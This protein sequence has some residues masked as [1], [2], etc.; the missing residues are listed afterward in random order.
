MDVLTGLL[1]GPRA[2]SAFLLKSMLDPPWSLRIQDEAPLTVVTVLTG[3]AWLVLDGHEP[4]QLQPGGVAIVRGPGHYTLADDPKRTPTVIVHPGQLTTDIEGEELCEAMDLGLRTWGTSA[5][6][7]VTMVT[8]TYQTPTEISRL[9]LETLPPMIVI[10][11][12]D[13]DSPFLQLLANEMAK[14]HVGQEVVLD[15]LLDLVVVAALRNWIGQEGSESPGKLG[16]RHDP[17]VQ[18]ALELVQRDPAHA[19]TVATLAAETGVS[20]AAFARRFSNVMGMPPMAYLT[21]WRLALAA[22]SLRDPRKTIG[23]VAREVGYGSAFALSTAFK[24]IRGVSPH[25]YRMADRA[26]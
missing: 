21:Q 4:A 26:S 12:A 8:G 20:R 23:A 18:T 17:V 3:V 9:L 19:W 1:N 6:G 14:D 15:R 25:H 11:E 22:D 7:S 10:P 24:R 5:A 2:N 16:S 13:G